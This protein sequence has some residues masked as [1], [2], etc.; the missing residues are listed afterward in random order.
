MAAGSLA[1]I[2]NAAQRA[3]P[4]I[5]D[6]RDN[7]HYHQRH[8]RGRGYGG[9]RR[10]SNDGRYGNRGNDNRGNDNHGNDNRN[11]GHNH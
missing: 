8:D 1:L 2:G 3:T 4:A 10:S 6:Q 7:G 9:D 11:R 5:A